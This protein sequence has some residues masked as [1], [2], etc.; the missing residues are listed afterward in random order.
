MSYTSVWHNADGLV[1][2]FGRVEA[3]KQNVGA[4][5]VLGDLHEVH[6]V[7]ALASLPAFG[8]GLANQRI[9][10]DSVRLPVGAEF[11]EVEVYVE[12][13]ATGA[14]AAFNLGLIREDRTTEIDFDGLIAPAT[15]G[16]AVLDTVGAIRVYRAEGTDSLP[17]P[18]VGGALIAGQTALTVPGLL[19]ASATTANF[20]A[21]Q[22]R[23]KIRYRVNKAVGQEG[24]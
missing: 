21:G 24:N 5:N 7:I 9:L 15:A 3:E 10:S 6:A 11:Q 20:T 16:V 19:V 23:L 17:V 8:T 1:V 4:H 14:T 18:A 2:P 12:V 22:L 13:G